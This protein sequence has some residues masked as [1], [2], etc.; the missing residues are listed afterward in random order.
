MAYPKARAPFV[1]QA[2]SL[3]DRPLV[4]GYKIF[5]TQTKCTVRRQLMPG[6]EAIPALWAAWKSWDSCWEHLRAYRPACILAKTRKKT[7]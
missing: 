7:A 4:N 3:P 2:S 6:V 1:V 5:N